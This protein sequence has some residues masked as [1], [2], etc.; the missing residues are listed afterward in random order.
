MDDSPPLFS[1]HFDCVD[2]MMRTVLQRLLNAGEPFKARKGDGKE[3]LGVS[4]RLN[5]P[6]A[7]LSRSEMRGKVY[8][9]LGEF[10]WYLSG[11]N[12]L[13]FIEYY[14]RRYE[15]ASD[16]GINVHGAYG[17]RLFGGPGPNQLR[18]VVR[19][20]QSHPSSRRAAI[21]LFFADDLSFDYKDIPCTCTMQA[22]RQKNLLNFVVYMRSNDAYIGLPHDV[23]AFTMLQ[24]MIARA[25]GL[26][27]GFY[28]HF[29]GNIHL[30]DKRYKDAQKFLDEGVGHLDPMPFMPEGDPWSG[31][32]PALLSAEAAIRNDP[33]APA[34][35]LDPYWED[36]L[37]LLRVYSEG[38]QEKPGFE[39]R[40][41]AIKSSMSSPTF[42]VYFP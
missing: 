36:I 18:N 32:V 14:L 9:G 39:E 17:P 2:D 30:Y 21:Q 28:Y 5:N 22:I 3:L 20:L 29:V 19:L 40:I 41:A 15:E 12:N 25:L 11:A 10:L 8:S 37:R 26:D 1:A 31:V 16:N 7:R 13:R 34:G 38:K 35:A 4:L 33:C 42:D 6:R 24:E 23:F 27:V